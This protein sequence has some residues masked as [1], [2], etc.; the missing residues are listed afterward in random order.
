M[1]RYWGPV[2]AMTFKDIVL[3]AR[4]KDIVVSVL[5]FALLVI[6][7]FNF[8]QFKPTLQIVRRHHYRPH[9]IR[10]A[11]GG[12]GTVWLTCSLMAV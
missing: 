7:I 12:S 9:W 4:S 2:L 8:A 11:V 1:R 3:E 5:V 10:A 6:V